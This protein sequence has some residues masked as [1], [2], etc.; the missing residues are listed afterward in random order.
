M[1]PTT[2]VSTE[3]VQHMN[4]ELITKIQELG[5]ACNELEAAASQTGTEHYVCAFLCTK[6]RSFFCPPQIKFSVIVANLAIGFT[7]IRVSHY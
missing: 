4:T 6:I 2:P 1:S 5:E 3:L 7:H